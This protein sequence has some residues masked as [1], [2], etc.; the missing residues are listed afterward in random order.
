MKLT[1]KKLTHH[2]TTVE[3]LGANSDNDISAIALENLGTGYDKAVGVAVL[4]TLRRLHQVIVG[5]LPDS[6]GL[7][8]SATLVAFDIMAGEEDAV[9][10]YDLT[11]FQQGYVADYD[12]LDVDNLLNVVTNDLDATFFLLLIQRLELALLLEVVEGTD[13]NLISRNISAYSQ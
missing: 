10:R 12:L 11:G 9:A 7:A 2:D 13:H 4:L 3:A 1:C 8:G 6:V 5:N